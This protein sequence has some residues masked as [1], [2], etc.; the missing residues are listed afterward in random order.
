MFGSI[1]KIN[2]NNNNMSRRLI[3][4]IQGFKSENN[5]IPKELAAYNGAQIM[6]YVFR[7]PFPLNSLPPS[8]QKENKWLMEN[9]HGLDWKE[10]FTPLYQFK[11]IMLN[12]SEKTDVFYVKGREKANFLRKYT[13]KDVLELD[14][15]PALPQLEPNCF[16]HLKKPCRCAL[17]NVLYLYNTSS[18]SK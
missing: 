4:D 11:N 18:F 15:K 9:L 6:H 14:E 8:I 10:A 3:I 13:E 12:I 17:S 16:Y 5:F 1:L 2:N 7:I